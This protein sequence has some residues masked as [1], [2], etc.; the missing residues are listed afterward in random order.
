MELLVSKTQRVIYGGDLDIAAFSNAEG[1]SPLHTVIRLAESLTS[2]SRFCAPVIDRI[3][4]SRNMQS[5]SSR[6]L[7]R[8]NSIY[9]MDTAG[10]YLNYADT[11]YALF[12]EFRDSSGK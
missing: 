4:E 2:K 6:S 9:S 3:Q 7:S 5:L 11:L 8:K 1:E 10:T 12:C